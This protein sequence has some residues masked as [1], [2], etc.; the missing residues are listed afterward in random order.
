[1]SKILVTGGGG[2]IGGYLVKNL[3][4]KK[5]DV[6]IVDDL[7]NKKGGLGYIHPEAEFIKYDITG[8][9]LYQILDNHKFDG[10]YH[11]TAQTCGE[12]SYNNPGGYKNKCIWYLACSKLL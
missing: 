7:Q 12:D 9:F 5:H 2:F 11:L 1:M 6:V 8:P 4:E 10:G 3:L